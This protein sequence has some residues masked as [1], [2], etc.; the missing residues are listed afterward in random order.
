LKAS[1]LVKHLLDAIVDQGDM[2]VVLPSNED[3]DNPHAP[4]AHIAIGACDCCN[5]PWFELHPA[6]QEEIAA[7]NASVEEF[8]DDIESSN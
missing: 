6:S 8:D 3:D 5:E 4:L 7:Y 1:T 2:D